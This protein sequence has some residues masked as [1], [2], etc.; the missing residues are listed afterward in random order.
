LEQEADGLQRALNDRLW[1]DERDYL[2]NR[3][4]DADDLHYYAGSLLGAVYGLLDGRRGEE[5]VAT[6]EQQLVD[7]RLG[8]RTVA[9]TD[10]HLD[11]VIAYFKLAGNEAG[12]PFFYING[13][14]WPHTTAWYIQALQTLGH[15]DRAYAFL[16]NTMTLDGIASSPNGQPALYEYR[17]TDTTS[18]KYGSIDKPSFLW[19]GGKFLEALYTVFGVREHEWNLSFVRPP[20]GFDTIRYS[21]SLGS[22]RHVVVTG[23]G[24]YLESLS[25]GGV[26]LPSSVLPFRPGEGDEIRI[27]WGALQRPYVSRLTAFLRDARYNDREGSLTIDIASFPGHEVAVDVMA[28]RPPLH[29]LLDGV[30][31]KGV[32]AESLD[33]GAYHIHAGFTADSGLQRLE[34]R[35]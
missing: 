21:L 10:F 5:L 27:Q 7:S 20:T 24:G 8:M 30:P 22:L 15:S 23:G 34:F 6:A 14:V 3:N 9:P 28:L 1:D 13:G 18:E 32:R 2:M 19:A 17:S 25:I 12:Q 26:D 35:F 11:S 33:D 16:R 29:V 31:L 4:G